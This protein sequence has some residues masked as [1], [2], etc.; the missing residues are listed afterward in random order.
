MDK[1][2]LVPDASLL[3]MQFLREG[4]KGGGGEKKDVV[5]A[6]RRRID[7]SGSNSM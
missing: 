6:E 7:S 5:E 1:C 2:D 4:L 3:M